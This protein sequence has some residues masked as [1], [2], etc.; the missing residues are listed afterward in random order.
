MTHLLL[1]IQLHASLENEQ[2]PKQA[3]MDLHGLLSNLG[4]SNCLTEQIG[5]L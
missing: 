5:M 2:M 1:M 4:L 3:Q